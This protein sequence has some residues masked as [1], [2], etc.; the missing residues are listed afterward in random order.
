[1]FGMVYELI[2]FDKYKYIRAPSSTDGDLIDVRQ[3][4]GCFLCS[5]CPETTC[6]APCDVG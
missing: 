5:I 6:K 4:N 1:M 2:Y 3:S